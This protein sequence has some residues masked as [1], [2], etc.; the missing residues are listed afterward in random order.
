[1]TDHS[2]FSSVTNT[3]PGGYAVALTALGDTAAA[4][5]AGQGVNRILQTDGTVLLTAEGGATSGRG[6]VAAGSGLNYIGEAKA[7]RIEASTATP[8]M[9]RTSF[10][11]RP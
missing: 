3:E 8:G 2:S 7:V 4:M 10:R 1:M 5:Y 11:V 6:M 9:R